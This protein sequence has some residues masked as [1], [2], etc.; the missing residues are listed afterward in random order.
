MRRM[1]AFAALLTGM[2]VAGCQTTDDPRAGGFISGITALNSGAY[3]NRIRQREAAVDELDAV[4]ASLE[5]RLGANERDLNRTKTE[6]LSLERRLSSLERASADTR[7]KLEAAGR[8]RK[9]DEKK[10][11]SLL[12]EQQSIELTLIAVLQQR[13]ARDKAVSSQVAE[14]PGNRP[15]ESVRTAQEQK[16]ATDLEERQRRL[17]NVIRETLGE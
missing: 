10:L 4:R 6:R 3:E 8:Q 15:E 5:R 9:L 11:A 12:S 7:T 2:S 14:M 13:R 17:Q 16:E 1:T